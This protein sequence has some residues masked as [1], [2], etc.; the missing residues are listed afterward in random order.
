MDLIPQPCTTIIDAMALLLM[1]SVKDIPGTFA[2]LADQILKKIIHIARYINSERVDF[3][4]DRYPVVSTKNAE[5][6]NRATS[7]TQSVTIL[8][9]NQKVP[10]QWKKF[11]NVSQNK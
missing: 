10:R 9:G 5:R 1:L 2:L 6:L 8:N 11:L 7:G 3:V 4:S